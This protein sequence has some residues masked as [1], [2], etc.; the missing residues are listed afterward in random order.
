MKTLRYIDGTLYSCLDVGN[1]DLPRARLNRR[2]IRQKRFT[3]WWERME[4]IRDS[5]RSDSTFPP[6]VP[7][8]NSLPVYYRMED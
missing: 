1:L 8:E 3:A 4:K 5:T 2:I 7:F 6:D